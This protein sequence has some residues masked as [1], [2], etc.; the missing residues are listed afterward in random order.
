MGILDP[1][2]QIADVVITSEGRKQLAAG[3]FKISYASVT[4]AGVVYSAPASGSY[5]IAGLAFLEQGSS[6][7]D[8]VTIESDDSGRL[9]PLKSETFNLVGSRIFAT[10]SFDSL[11]DELT[12]LPSVNLSRQRILMT[13][14]KDFGDDGFAAGPSNVSFTV[15]QEKPV[16]YAIVEKIE[17]H[18]SLFEDPDMS[19]LD[20]F[21]YLPP[22]DR[23]GDKLGIYKPS[24]EAVK[25]KTVSDVKKEMKSYPSKKIVFD[26]TTVDGNIIMQSYE[27]TGGNIS[28]LQARVF[29]ENPLIVFLGKTFT[30]TNGCD[31]FVRIFC[32]EFG[33]LEDDPYKD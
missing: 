27:Y 2:S 29:S 28:K 1:A 24:G 31:N 10:G 8:L 19:T 13:V 9:A 14:N 5:D 23:D 22:V 18:D 30:D 17:D 32:L 16:N 4:D 25:K 7:H 20:N 6:P 3:T 11:T 12:A 15:T 33:E 26:P 21:S